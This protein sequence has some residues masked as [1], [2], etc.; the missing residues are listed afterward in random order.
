M[1][2]I[3]VFTND[4][5]N[6]PAR[7]LRKSHRR[8]TAVP[9]NFYFFFASLMVPLIRVSKTIV[10]D[11]LIL[12]KTFVGSHTSP[13]Y[14]RNNDRAAPSCR[15]EIRIVQEIAF[16]TCAFNPDT[17]T[18]PSLP[19]PPP[20]GAKC[21]FLFFLFYF[22]SSVSPPPPGRRPTVLRNYTQHRNLNY[23]C[24]TVA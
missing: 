6:V 7:R 13:I 12:E 17:P 21:P 16:R 20:T 4:P 23:C 5:R 22:I 2:I 19:L 1:R 14:V 11:G 10:D 24:Y 15:R 9:S 3:H 18:A 8:H